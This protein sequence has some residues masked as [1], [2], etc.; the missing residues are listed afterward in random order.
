M[1]DQ[2]RAAG[3]S[4]E[5][6]RE[7]A[8][9][10]RER[11]E[12]AR[13]QVE[14]AREQVETARESA[15][16]ARQAA[17]EAQDASQDQP[18]PADQQFGRP[19]RPLRRDSPFMI[20]FLGALGVLLALGIVH[21]I[22]QARS[23]L[24]LIAV[25]LFLAVGLN[26]I[27][28]GL[29]Q[30]GM[31]RGVAIGI[32]FAAVIGAFVG[33]GFAVVPPV[34]E[35]TNAFIK[36]LPSYLED[37]RGNRTIRQFDNDYHVI[38]KAQDYVTGPD[39][40]QRVFGGLL[41]VGRI[42]VNAVFSAFSM[43]IMTLYFLAALPSMK[44]Q[45]YRLVPATRRHRVTL[46]TD[47]ILVRIGGFVSGALT[48]AFIAA[49]CSWIFLL[50]VHMPFALALAVFVGLLDLVP[51][52]GASIAAVAVSALGF[53]QSPGTGIACILFYVAYQQVENYLIY[54][55]VMRRAVD[56]PA[57][58]TV[59]AVLIGGAL[60]G[61]TGALLAIPVAA[62]ALLVIRQVT[63]PRMDRV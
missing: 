27:V 17:R 35:Q 47:E 56:V 24:I 15:E 31:R 21:A 9:T 23:V 48:V 39:L 62:A 3:P 53:I 18:E 36:E 33:F 1:S 54:P 14:A 7:R 45:A 63:I 13:E 44:R 50:I 58:V 55:R 40:G 2:S 25:A 46:L 60:L 29:C 6:A 19:G 34:V 11:A 16:A 43:L 37:L 49:T 4:G 10:A 22:S 52:V 20:G 26:P 32:V 28:D 38:Q 41:G 57:P 30:R 5:T 59:V 42:V 12:T 8:E 61:V 51:L